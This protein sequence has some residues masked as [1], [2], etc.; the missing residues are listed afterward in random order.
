[1]SGER[2]F[3][4]RSAQIAAALPV[5]DVE[6]AIRRDIEALATAPG[7]LTDRC[8][9]ETS[10]AC[11]NTDNEGVGSSPWNDPAASYVEV[12]STP[13]SS[14]DGLR[15]IV[16]LAAVAI[17]AFRC[18][19]IRGLRQ[20][21]L[22]GAMF[23]NRQTQEFYPVQIDQKSPFWH[24]T[25]GNVSWHLR[26]VAG[27]G[28]QSM[29]LQGSTPSGHATDYAAGTD[30]SLLV[31]NGSALRPPAAG[32]PPG[33]GIGSLGTFRD[34]RFPWDRQSAISSLDLEVQGPVIV[35]F[36]ASIRQT[37]PAQRQKLGPLLPQN[38][39]TGVLLPE[40][41][42]VLALDAT[43]FPAIYRGVAGSIV[44]ETNQTYT[45]PGGNTSQGRS[46]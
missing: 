26:I 25:D 14:I 41:Q 1:M 42:F 19:R 18:F 8:T 37:N 5:V 32:I 36:Y 17:P 16:R 40:D 13:S 9:V 10:T 46:P 39:P 22:I 24:F 21:V 27:P 38:F 2:D 3:Q 7:F 43:N 4:G 44:M 20:A 45:R 33:H 34:I 35:A 6:E 30:P 15:Y 29:G 28:P 12:P 31:R 23:E 11:F